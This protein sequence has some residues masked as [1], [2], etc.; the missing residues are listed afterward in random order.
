[1]CFMNYVCK[2]PVCCCR[3][4][5]SDQATNWIIQDM[6]LAK[7]HRREIFLYSKFLHRFWEPRGFQFS[8][9]RDHF[10]VVKRMRPEAYNDYIVQRLKMSGAIPPPLPCGWSCPHQR[11]TVLSLAVSARA[12]CFLT[13]TTSV[14]YLAENCALI[15]A[16]KRQ[17]S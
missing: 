4:R 6:W 2:N 5:S 16:C 1:M 11:G 10:L 12:M 14:L 15:S 13:R 7:R 9:Y 17:K 8:G 3:C